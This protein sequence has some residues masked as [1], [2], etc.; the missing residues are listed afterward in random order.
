MADYDHAAAAAT[1]VLWDGAAARSLAAGVTFHGYGK[2]GELGLVADGKLSVLLP[3][4]PAPRAVAGADRIASFDVSPVPFPAC[5]A[6]QGSA[7][8]LVARRTQAAGGELLAAGCALDRVEPLERAQVGDYRF[9]AASPWLAYTVQG[10]DG[11]TLR[12]VQTEERLATFE[13]GRATRAFAFGPDGRTVAFIA[14]AAPGKQGD[15]HVGGAGRKDAVLAREVGEFAWARAAPRLAWLERYDPRVRSGTLGVGGLDLLSHT[16]ASS[17]SEVELSS[18]GEH[19]AFLRHTSRG[20]YSVDLG[21]AGLDPAASATTV[22]TGVFGFAFSPD[23]RWL[24]YRTRCLRNA[25]ACDLERVPASGLAPGAAPERIAEGVKSFEFDPR[26]P[27]RLL[28]GWQRADL[29]ALDIGVWEQ[30]KVT[31]VDSAVLPGSAQLLAPDSRK[32]AYVVIAPKRQGV[33]VA[34]LPPL[35]R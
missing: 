13:L 29:V 4:E 18:D 22:A 10:K 16:V 33:Y 7:V 32:L 3:G 1:L 12:V 30:G 9:G 31:R 14:D 28:L 27:G 2:H 26:D 17:I 8:R 23:A 19:V 6:R 25:E 15:L 21:L 11:A 5:G 24:Y 35:S 20:G 34:E